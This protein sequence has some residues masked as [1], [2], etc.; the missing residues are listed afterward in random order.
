MQAEFL[1]SWVVRILWRTGCEC[2]DRPLRLTFRYCILEL[3]IAALLSSFSYQEVIFA[4][5]VSFQISSGTGGDLWSKD[6][7]D[8]RSYFRQSIWTWLDHVVEE[9]KLH[10]LRIYSTIL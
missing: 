5:I 4:L 10:I 1:A 2:P 7:G 9:D 6:R 3:A 8:G